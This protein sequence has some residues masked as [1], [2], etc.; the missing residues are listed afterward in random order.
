[1]T[2]TQ[3]QTIPSDC[4]IWTTEDVAV[5]FRSSTE[6]VTKQARLKKIPAF[7]WGTLW[8]FERKRILSLDLAALE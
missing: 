5:Y 1:M 7:K 4:E 8:R 6:M 2:D 3:T